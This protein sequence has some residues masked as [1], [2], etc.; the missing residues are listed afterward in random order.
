MFARLTLWLFCLS[1]FACAT[2][3]QLQERQRFA[4]ALDKLGTSTGMIRVGKVRHVDPWPADNP[5]A[6]VSVYFR[7][8]GDIRLMNVRYT[9]NDRLLSFQPKWSN[10]ADLRDGLGS[11]HVKDPIERAL[12]IASVDQFHQRY[13]WVYYGRPAIQRLGR[14]FLVTYYTVSPSDPRF[15]DYIDPYVSFLITP[16]GTLIATFWGA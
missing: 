6:T 8:D 5:G 1:L 13:P 2:P 12:C 11:D 16:R 10:L 9:S 4:A 3:K 14:D 7:V 15:L